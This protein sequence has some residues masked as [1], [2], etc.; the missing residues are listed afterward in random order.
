M[1][2]PKGFPFAKDRIS[3]SIAFSPSSFLYLAYPDQPKGIKKEG[4]CE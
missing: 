1:N 2:P 3:S 4:D